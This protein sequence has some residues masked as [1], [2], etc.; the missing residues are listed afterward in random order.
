V[1][2]VPS[3]RQRVVLS[4]YLDR[5]PPRTLVSAATVRPDMVLT[6]GERPELVHMR[7]RVSL[8]SAVAARHE[9]CDL[10]WRKL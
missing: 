9:A 3:V 10:R 8:P 6:A 7:M 4:H 5:L 2:D 1:F